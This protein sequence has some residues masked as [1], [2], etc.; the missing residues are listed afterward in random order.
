M[1]SGIATNMPNND[2]ATAQA[3]NRAPIGQPLERLTLTGKETGY[4]T[5]LSQTTLWRLAARGLLTPIPGLRHRVYSRAAVEK[6]V[7]RVA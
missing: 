4:V 2:T 1:F 3:Q 6:F 5:G 7:N